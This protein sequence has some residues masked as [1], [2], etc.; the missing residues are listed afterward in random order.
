MTQDE[1]NERIAQGSVY[2]LG[3]VANLDAVSIVGQSPWG[4]N[5]TIC[6]VAGRDRAS[7]AAM[8]DE[9]RFFIPEEHPKGP[10]NEEI[11]GYF[12]EGCDAYS[13]SSER[14][15][16]LSGE[17][18]LCPRETREMVIWWHAGALQSRLA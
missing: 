15:Q 2:M 7:C 4:P 18:W 12:P 10:G 13:L 11:F 8:L 9:V 3:V 5:R 17:S 14:V 6:F 16:L 1:L